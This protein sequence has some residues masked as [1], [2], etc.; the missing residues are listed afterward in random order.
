MEDIWP[1]GKSCEI[2]V[3]ILVLLILRGVTL[4]GLEF[5]IFKVVIIIMKM[6]PLES[7]VR[8]KGIE[9]DLAQHLVRTWLE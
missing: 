7:A 2:W 9:F 3:Q 5:L 1:G 6:I 4:L 8:V